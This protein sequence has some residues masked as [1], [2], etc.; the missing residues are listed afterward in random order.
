MAGSAVGRR[1]QVGPEVRLLLGGYLVSAVGSGM[2]F[3]YLAI[4]VVEARQQSE[5]TAAVTLAVVAA[6][7]V[8]GSLVG[9]AWTDRV[10]P[11]AVGSAGIGV[12]VLGYACLGSVGSSPLLLLAGAT[13]GWGAGAFLAV[14]SPSISR[15]VPPALHRR[16]FALRYLVNNLGIGLGALLAV[17]VLG[18]FSAARFQLLYVVNSASYLV[19]LGC[20]RRALARVGGPAPSVVAAPVRGERRCGPHADRRFTVLLLVQ[21]LLVAAGFSQVQSVVPF[22]LSVRLDA[23]PEVISTMLALNCFGVV[24]L[25]PVVVHLCRRVADRRLLGCVGL[26]WAVA[27]GVGAGVV[28]GGAAGTGALLVFFLLFTLGECCYAPSFQPLLV[29]IAPA[30]R[31]GHYSGVSSSLWGLTTF[32]APPLGILLVD[33]GDSSWFWPIC[34][35]LCLLASAC[36]TRLPE[37]GSRPGGRP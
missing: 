14:L 8:T 7:T 11:R 22:F 20:F 37:A 27:F 16:A 4:Y 19:L 1:D 34:G 36:V 12:Q 2:V 33:S 13:V 15:L 17:L 32:V 23:D 25:Q 21:T 30:G 18:S 3:P 24:L 9:G 10:G 6:G 28:A 26:L 29:R 5:T 35:G 31:L